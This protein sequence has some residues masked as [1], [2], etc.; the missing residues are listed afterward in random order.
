MVDFEKLLRESLAGGT[1]A[2]EQADADLHDIVI[3]ASQALSRVSQ[4]A[5]DL[6]LRTLVENLGGVIYGLVI[7]ETGAR[8]S[9]DAVEFYQVPPGGYPIRTG[10]FTDI[11]SDSPEFHPRLALENKA[12]LQQH[13]AEMMA[14]PDS[15]LVVIVAFFMRRQSGAAE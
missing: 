12:E 1:K 5:A 8:S 10:G 4:G 14:N 2:F 9:G 6:V 7:R 11:E 3:E 13:F 15:P